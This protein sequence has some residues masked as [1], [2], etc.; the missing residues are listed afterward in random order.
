MDANTVRDGETVYV[1][2][3]DSRTG[4]EGPFFVTYVDADG[5]DPYGYFCSACESFDNAMDPMGRIVCN[6]CGNV[7]KPEEWDAI[8]E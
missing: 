2:R 7:R 1:D 6:R 4:S 3:E 5:N 8:N